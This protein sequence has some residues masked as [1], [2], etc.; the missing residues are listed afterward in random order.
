[1]DVTMEAWDDTLHV[2]QS[3]GLHDL[4][5]SKEAIASIGDFILKRFN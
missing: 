3:F 1:M 5:E 4:P 2:F